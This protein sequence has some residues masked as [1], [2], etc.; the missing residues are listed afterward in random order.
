MTPSSEGG[1][2]VR[3]RALS[4]N[5][6]KGTPVVGSAPKPAVPATRS[7]ASKIK[8]P[9]T[10]ERQTTATSTTTSTRQ[11]RIR[12]YTSRLV[13]TPSPRIELVKKKVNPKGQKTRS[14]QQKGNDDHSSDAKQS[15]RS[16]N[17]IRNERKLHQTQKSVGKLT[18][19]NPQSLLDEKVEI[20]ETPVSNVLEQ[21]VTPEVS[22][23]EPTT[24]H[25]QTE[26]SEGEP[27]TGHHQTEVSG[28]EP[29]H[30]RTELRGGEPTDHRTEV[31][32]GEPT[33]GHHQTEGG[34]ISVLDKQI[35]VG[36]V[37]IISHNNHQ[38][39][40]SLPDVKEAIVE[41]QDITR[42][43]D[44]HK[45][46]NQTPVEEHGQPLLEYNKIVH[47]QTHTTSNNQPHVDKET[48]E[49]QQLIHTTAVNESR[50]QR[51][52][53]DR[54]TSRR[55]SEVSE[56]SSLLENK[57]PDNNTILDG[58][59]HNANL[60]TYRNAMS[61]YLR[62][63][64]DR[65]DIMNH[66]TVSID[67]EGI[68]DSINLEPHE[69][70]RVKVE[71][72]SRR[73]VDGLAIL[74]SK[75]YLPNRVIIRANGLENETV[76]CGNAVFESCIHEDTFVFRQVLSNSGNVS[77]DSIT[78]EIK[79]GDSPACVFSAEAF[80][81]VDSVALQEQSF[82]NRN[83]IDSL[84]RYL[85]DFQTDVTEMRQHPLLEALT[86][87][88]SPPPPPSPPPPASDSYK[89]FYN[90]VSEVNKRKSLNCFIEQQHVTQDSDIYDI[91]NLEP[92]AP[93]RNLDELE[94]YK[95][96]YNSIN[97]HSDKQRVL[98]S[99]QSDEMFISGRQ[100]EEFASQQR[101]PKYKSRGLSKTVS[102]TSDY[103]PIGNSRVASP[104]SDFAQIGNS[105]VAA[106]PRRFY[107]SEVGKL[108]GKTLKDGSYAPIG[109]TSGSQ[110]QTHLQINLGNKIQNNQFYSDVS[111]GKRIRKTRGLNQETNYIQNS[112]D[113]VRRHKRE[114]TN[115]T[116]RRSSSL[117]KTY[118][119]ERPIA[120]PV[121]RTVRIEDQMTGSRSAANTAQSV[122]S[123]LSD[124][125]THFD[126]TPH[127]SDLLCDSTSKPRSV[128]H[129][130]GVIIA[131]QD[132]IAYAASNKT[133]RV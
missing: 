100:S 56:I 6:N 92:Y 25:H 121:R 54:T 30:H 126:G 60:D 130:K 2:E 7:T 20:T 23:G 118:S 132:R 117:R 26:V 28:G 33:A 99:Q 96:I 61:M 89:H 86:S 48:S 63:A 98:E 70:R 21:Q 81:Y 10:R 105:R 43:T 64:D 84:E 115:S 107:H 5:H 9:V 44:T 37:N 53:S 8:H 69:S 122:A 90:N 103:A 32:E 67:K 3:T 125:N 45:D 41:T 4:R 87:L 78:L 39:S 108:Q 83:N 17:T 36:E 57:P 29:T 97:S 75:R 47:P 120:A 82:E 127:L 46:L 85:K 55:Q 31:S 114:I 109:S 15:K 72:E 91:N 123:Q 1:K 14:F 16:D 129:S 40:D 52:S 128:N 38:S 94:P 113:E 50:T 13:K 104:T 59:Y 65:I 34:S 110:S 42:M 73:V 111:E 66:R 12:E 76:M 131:A 88:E 101:Q 11:S 58:I 112:V 62:N 18:A 80:N 124:R 71:L 95:P 102:P 93:I 22:R 74:L 35:D 77:T 119:A 49:Q 68:E 116:N 27:T 106:S 19:S 79:A 51:R 133:I 24:G